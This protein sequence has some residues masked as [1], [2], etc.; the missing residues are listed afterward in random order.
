MSDYLKSRERFAQDLQ[1]FDA[2]FEELGPNGEMDFNE[3]CKSFPPQGGSAYP[4]RLLMRLR[5]RSRL[6]IVNDGDVWVYTGRRKDVHELEPLK[7]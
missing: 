4:W 2:L 7:W 5:K 6:L 1:R 3:L